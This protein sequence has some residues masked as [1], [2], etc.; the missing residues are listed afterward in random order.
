M[1]CHIQLFIQKIL[2][3]ACDLIYIFKMNINL[4][5]LRR[6]YECL[7]LIKLSINLYQNIEV[8]HIV[9]NE[10]YALRIFNVF[11]TLRQNMAL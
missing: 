4:F 11:G 8:L 2:Q 3:A 6:Q 10:L 7:Y 1:T 5:S 9:I